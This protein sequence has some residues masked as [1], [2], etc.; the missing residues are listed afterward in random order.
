MIGQITANDLKVKGISAID[1]MVNDNYG[2][3]ITVRGV[4]KYVILPIEE[5]NHLREMELD[6][7]I[8]ESK[9]EIAEGK[10]HSGSIEEHLKRVGNV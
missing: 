1:D 4:E 9:R 5:Y 7:A 6:S 3:V 10:Y 2:I 8:R